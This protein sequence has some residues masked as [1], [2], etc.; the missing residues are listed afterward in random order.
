MIQLNVLTG[1]AAGHRFQATTFPVSVGRSADC[2]LSLTD[3]GVF[4][5]HFEIQFSADGF[6]LLPHEH[7]V[8]SVNG[9]AVIQPALLRNG[10]VIG[11]GYAK[12]QFSLGPM[13]QKSLRFREAFTWLLVLGVAAAQVYLVSRLLAIAH[14]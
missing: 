1:A 8:I 12:L 7:A 4:E 3:P 2:S 14:S 13:R 11:A 10:D 9:A 6:S 5:R